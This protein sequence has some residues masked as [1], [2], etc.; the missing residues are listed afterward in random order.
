[1]DQPLDEKQLAISTC[2]C[3]LQPGEA[4]VAPKCAAVQAVG[5]SNRLLEVRSEKGWQVCRNFVSF[6]S[7]QFCSCAQRIK[8]FKSF[9]V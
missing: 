5:S 6:G 8:V 3:P 7:G 2:S 9:G 1:M 4:L